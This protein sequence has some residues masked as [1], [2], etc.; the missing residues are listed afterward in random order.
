MSAQPLEAAIAS[1][2]SV[3]GGVSNDELEAATPCASWQVRELV[4]HIVGGQRFFAAMARGEEFKPG[5]EDWCAG[6]FAAD[7]DAGA[8]ECLAAFAAPGAMEKIMHL[9]FGD[10]PG[11]AFVGIAATDT[12]VHG[13]DLAKATGQDTNLDPELAAGL[14][15]GAQA[16]IQES[17]R[18]NEPMPFGPQ[19]QAPPGASPADELAAFLGRV[20]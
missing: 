13:W 7:F 8:T 12:F 3:L 18:G 17:F 9:P 16:F 6:D 15:V 2:R 1:T 5:Q 20:V 19:Q 11:A 10:M 14:L 4:N